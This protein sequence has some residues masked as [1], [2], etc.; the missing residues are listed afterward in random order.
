MVNVGTRE[1]GPR[2]R[3]EERSEERERRYLTGGDGTAQA[4]AGPKARTAGR[5]ASERAGR[6]PTPTGPRA[7][8]EHEGAQAAG[9]AGGNGT[10]Q[11]TAGLRGADGQD[12]EWS[13]A[14]AAAGS[15][16]R[17]TRGAAPQEGFTSPN[18]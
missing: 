13:S 5:T 16:S 17:P 11:A 3:G 4:A 10:A 9:R 18:E 15:T 12:K 2:E 6:G 1:G 14:R 8:A 7:G